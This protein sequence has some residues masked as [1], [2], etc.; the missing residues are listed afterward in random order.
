MVSG[1]RPGTLFGLEV[2]TATD[3]ALHSITSSARV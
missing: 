3:L 2:I 1:W